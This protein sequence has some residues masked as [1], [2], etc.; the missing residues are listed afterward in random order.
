MLTRNENGHLSHLPDS[1][2]QPK[3]TLLKLQEHYVTSSFNDPNA[4]CDI[5]FR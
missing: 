5:L 4:L 1:L 2:L 3:T